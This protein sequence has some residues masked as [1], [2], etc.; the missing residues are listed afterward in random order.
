MKSAMPYRGVTS[1]QLRRLLRPIL[2]DPAHQ[3][4]TREQWEHTVRAL[5]DEA[6]HREERYAATALSRHRYYR[7]HQDSDTI[8]LYR[9]MIVTGAWWDHVDEIAAHLVGGILLAY[10]S[11]EQPRMR[12]WAHADDLWLR[13]TA[14]LSQLRF[15]TQ[16]SRPLLEATIEANLLGSPFG[17]EF[18]IRKAIGW[19]LRQY[20][21]TDPAWVAGYVTQ[22]GDRLA[23]L[24]RREATKHLAG[25]ATEHTDPAVG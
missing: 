23:P 7:S 22:L 14:I 20:A 21:R 16:T 11:S 8:P 10:P 5:W 24:S 6:S 25:V 13:R 4:A 15:A 9:H 2:N 18:F 1:P 17:S 19:A 3:L 12:D